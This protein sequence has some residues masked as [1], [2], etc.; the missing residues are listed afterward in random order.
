MWPARRGLGITHLTSRCAQIRKEN[1]A[2][3]EPTAATDAP[4][5]IIS[6]KVRA[7]VV[8]SGG[9]QPRP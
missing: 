2:M 5:G 9:F 6:V 7:V 1:E 4:W 8:S 3:G